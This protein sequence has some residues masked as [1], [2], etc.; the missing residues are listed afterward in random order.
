[1][2]LLINILTAERKVTVPET[3]LETSSIQSGHVGLKYTQNLRKT[4]ESIF[5][6]KSNIK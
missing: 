4:K 3:E 1:V 5:N 2:I 6:T